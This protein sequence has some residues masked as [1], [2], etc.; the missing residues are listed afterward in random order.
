MK[1]VS[2][3]PEPPI[4]ILITSMPKSNQPD[5]P[6]ICLITAESEI[7]SEYKDTH[8]RLNIF[9]EIVCIWGQN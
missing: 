8:E 4:G 2:N 5:T 1:L 3:L 9:V 6:V 7:L